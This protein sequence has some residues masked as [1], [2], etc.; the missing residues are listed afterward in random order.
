MLLSRFRFTIGQLVQVIVLSAVIFWIMRMSWGSS[1]VMA[2]PAFDYFVRA[3]TAGAMGIGRSTICRGL[4]L[5][6]L[7]IA[8][9]TYFSVFAIPLAI[10]GVEFT[11]AIY[12]LIVIAPAFSRLWR[13]IINRGY[14]MPPTDEK[15]GP[16]AW[17]SLTELPRPSTIHEAQ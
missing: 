12:S 17:A 11:F 10:S 8:Y 15:C 4:V 1:I 9:C 7:G 14:E 16:I 2:F 5:I 3:R 6:A 13:T